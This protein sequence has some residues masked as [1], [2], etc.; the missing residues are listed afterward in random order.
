MLWSHFLADTRYKYDGLGLFEG[1]YTY[2]SGVWRPT[3]NSIMRHN[4]DGFNAPSRERIYYRIHK[5]AYG[6]S[7]QYNYEDFVTFDAVSRKTSATTATAEPL[8]LR[9]VEHTPPVVRP[10]SW[11][12]ALKR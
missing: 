10:Y 5:L 7:W 2:W 8:I 4:T 1:G 3:D 11:S 6:T 9:P 12:E